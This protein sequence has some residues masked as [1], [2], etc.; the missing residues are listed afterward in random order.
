MDM[1]NKYYLLLLIA[2][3][4]FSQTKEQRQAII[5]NT[6]TEAL[7]QLTAQFDAEHLE[8]KIRIDAYLIKHPEKTRTFKEGN[9][10]KEIYDVL[11][12]GDVQYY[13]TTN[14][15]A[16]R[17]ARADKL[18]NGGALGLNI[19]GQD[20]YAY[21]WDG[22]A[23]R[24]THQEFPGSKVM[25][26][27]GTVTLSDHGTHVMGTI[28]AQGTKAALRGIAF[29]AYGVS[30]NWDSD[31][32]EMSA[33]AT[34]GMLVSNHS[35]TITPAAATEWIFGAYDNRSR[36]FDQIANA[37]PYYLAV[38]A[39]GNDRNDNADPLIGPYLTEKFGFNLIKGMQNSKNMLTVG[40][41]SQVLTYTGPASVAMSSFSSWGPTDDGR[42][43]PEVVTKGVAVKSPVA[44]SDTA[45]DSYPG[46]SMASPGVAGVGLLLQQYQ[47]SLFGEYMRAASLKGLI[48]HSADEAGYD[49]GP[50]YSF[51]W[52]LVNAQR[53]ATILQSK[54]AETAIVSELVLNNG[55]SYTTTLAATGT[56]PLMVSIS[57][58][59][60]AA[61]ANTSAEIDPTTLYLINDLDIR[62]T[63]DGETF[64][65]WTLDP[66]VPYEPAVRNTDNFRDNFEKIQIDSPNGVYTITVTHKGTTLRGGMQNYTLIASSDNGISLSNED[67]VLNE[68]NIFLYPNPA[69]DV[70]NYS[71]STDVALKSVQVTDISGKIIFSNNSD[72][73]SNQINVSDL[74]SGIYFVTFDSENGAFTK[75]FI[76]R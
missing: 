49:L 24:V 46:T 59:D 4:G 28:V 26:A 21:V 43:K 16:A 47:Y 38:A 57:W 34:Y 13:S 60:P 58:N 68:T 19:Q 29:D 3:L 30:Y 50:D 32:S 63:K 31:Y 18:Y 70:L 5:K 10:E 33:Q 75:K 42:I 45:D 1:K 11:P 73:S 71:F 2:S 61:I 55:G 14:F 72:L 36:Q 25:V 51:G 64:Y 66:A 76:K 23:A 69:N 40:A 37:A 17:T 62:V 41:V 27:D 39:A 74:S 8:R 6:D 67:F 65:P 53:A 35:Y 48:M 56:S 12:N 20:M 15:N 9:V 54:Q 52:G 7:N 22:G 44:S